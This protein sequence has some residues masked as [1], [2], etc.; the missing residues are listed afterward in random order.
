MDFSMTYNAQG[1]WSWKNFEFNNE[2]WKPI[3]CAQT[4]FI[5]VHCTLNLEESIS[6]CDR[7][8]W[9]ESRKFT[10]SKNG[11][12]YFLGLASTLSHFHFFL[13]EFKLLH[14]QAL[15]LRKKRLCQTGRKRNM[16]YLRITGLIRN[17]ERKLL[18]WLGSRSQ[19]KAPKTST[20]LFSKHFK[21]K[22]R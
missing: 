1:L 21:K 11:C 19:L 9:L 16:A 5:F 15:C 13:L 18:N 2:I 14:Q 8:R 20:H 10:F 6:S 4:L 22:F 3:C 12:F 7:M 17:L